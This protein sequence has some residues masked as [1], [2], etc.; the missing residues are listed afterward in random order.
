[1]AKIRKKGALTDLQE[2]F[3]QHYSVHWNARRAAIQAGY[4]RKTAKEQGYQLLKL[5]RIRRRIAKL[6]EHTLLELGVSRA[7]VLAELAAIAFLDP[8]R[9][10]EADGQLKPIREIPLGVRRAIAKVKSEELFAGRGTDRVS[11]GYAR[12]LEF[13]PK[14]GA[15]DSLAKHL[16]LAPERH[17]HSGP[18][19]KPI[20]TRDVTQ[21]TDEQLDARIA[22][23]L[24]K[25]KEKA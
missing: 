10:Y 22:A 20:E 24:G 2:S 13:V 18:N 17:E 5:R 11:I 23:K 19:G 12:E 3:C 21:L 1:M 7:R 6:T 8:A 14:K 9:A 16:G 15:L 25:V 4:S